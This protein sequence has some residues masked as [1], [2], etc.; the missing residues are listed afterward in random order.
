M[1]IYGARSP[2]KS[3]LRQ[4]DLLCESRRRAEKHYDSTLV[5][6]L[7]PS[8]NEAMPSDDMAGIYL[9]PAAASPVSCR[10][11]KESWTPVQLES[12]GIVIMTSSRPKALIGLRINP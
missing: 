9:V 8:P 5:T 4:V 3:S 10:H 12:D 1:H 2:L 7:S 11:I 6:T